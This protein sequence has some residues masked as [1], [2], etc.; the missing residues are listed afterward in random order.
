MNGRIAGMLGLCRRAGKVISGTTVVEKGI[1]RHEVKM[2]VLAADAAPRS[3]EK[4]IGLARE[5]KIPV[6]FYATKDELGKLLG[7]A[8]RTVA[9]ITDEQIARGI[10]GAME[11]GDAGL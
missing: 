9:A 1:L 6:V 2:L 5:H 10:A 11:R 3:K 4:F 7:K 8:P